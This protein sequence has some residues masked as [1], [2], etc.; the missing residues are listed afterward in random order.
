MR[1][2]YLIVLPVLLAQLAAPAGA[3]PIDPGRAEPSA[4]AHT[5]QLTLITGDRVT[6]TVLADGKQAASV[7]ASPRE[8]GAPVYFHTVSDADGYYVIPSDAGAGIASG[9]LDRQLFNVSGLVEQGLTDTIPVITKGT[10]TT[11]RRATTL[12][13]IGATATRID[14][15]ATFWRDLHSP[16]T[17]TAGTTKVW[18]DRTVEVALEQTV[19][20]VGAPAA[21]R[22][23]F[24]GTGVTVAV[25]D[26]GVDT[27]HPDL[28]G[29]IAATA[30]F[31]TDPDA[32]D[33]HGH[34]THVASTV[35]G[36]GTASDGRYRGVA[37]GA[38]LVIGKVLPNSGA[39]PLSAVIAGMEW[40][41]RGG[42]D[43][44][45]MSL[46][47]PPTD[48]TDPGSLAVEALTEETGALFVVASGNDYADA[49][50]GT[51][52]AAAK[53][54]AVGAVDKQD[55]LAPYSNRGPR[56][57]DA[58]VKPELTAPGSDVVA[59]RAAGTAMGSP[60]DDRYTQASGTSMATPHVAG[61]AA[62]L[63][64][65]HPDWSWA[66]LKDALVSTANPGDYTVF[67]GGTGRL[68][69]A[70]AVTQVVRGP[71]AVSI[72][73]IPAPWQE[74]RTQ[75]L[76]YHNDG[77]EPVTLDLALI[78]HGWDGRALPD[79]ALS[80][81]ADRLTVPANGAATVTL[82]VD[83]AAG[84][85]GAYVAL[86]SATAGETRL[87]TAV[88]YYKATAAHRLTVRTLDSAGRPGTPGM[89]I[90]AVKLDGALPNDPFLQQVTWGWGDDTGSVVLNVAGG[91][92][93]VYGAVTEYDV[94]GR[95]TTVMAEPEL[96][97]TGEH[98][99]TL[100]ARRGVPINPR[101]PERTDVLSLAYGTLRGFEGGQFGHG[102]LFDF[103]SWGYYV[104][105]T[106][107]VETGWL[108]AYERWR[109]GTRT[110]E[111]EVG[112]DRIGREELDVL[113]RPFY[114]APKLAGRH[115]LPLVFAG[116]GTPAEL[117]AA[118]VGG[119][120][121]LVR[122]PIPDGE[123]FR[124]GYAFNAA[125]QVTADAAAAGAAA[126]L[127]YVAVPG[128]WGIDFLPGELIPQLSVSYADGEQLRQH[129][130]ERVTR[131]PATLTIEGRLNPERIYQ[132][133]YRTEGFVPDRYDR[134]VDLRGLARID[135]EYRTDRPGLADLT[136][137][138]GFSPREQ[139]QS[140][141][142]SAFWVPAS[143]TEYVGPTAD[144]DLHWLRTTTQ[145]TGGRDL[146]Y[147]QTSLQA[148][149]RFEPGE[150]PTRE[151]WFAPPITHGAVEVPDGYA[152][153]LR[154]AF[155]RHGDFFLPG[156][157]YLDGDP[158]HYAQS[159]H[160]T[161][162]YRLFRDGQEVP[163][164]GST[165]NPRFRLPAGESTYRLDAVDTQPLGPDVRALA[166]RVQ[167]SWTFQSSP[168]PNGA[169]PA[170]YSC[171]VAN[172]AAGCAFQPLLRPRYDLD[173]DGLNRAIAGQTFT[174]H[175]DASPHQAA[176]YDGR[177]NGLTVWASTDGGA[178][179]QPA[180]TYR[181][182]HDRFAVQVEHPRLDRTD[183]FVWLR[184][185]A[186]DSHGNTVEQLIER[187]Y[188]L[189]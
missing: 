88:S 98:T 159:F 105:P 125:Q 111:V 86:V 10:A 112:S 77:S 34:G 153:E 25:L 180:R 15:P 71:G 55:V 91:R 174:F 148:R 14:A 1:A 95:R 182:G 43:V 90:Y 37:P 42:A 145:T 31:T 139:F 45:S 20:Q 67:Q 72:G 17:R 162:T 21:W 176:P 161:S 117:A 115:E 78:G 56:R 58:A 120:A 76:T 23:G 2:R 166:T 5:H 118:G 24:D 171:P 122:I 134:S 68:D 107:R 188:A 12:T 136:S 19:P 110:A 170:G 108:E 99:V 127:P 116:A 85:P 103:D 11:A 152:A 7:Q 27:T 8:G 131:R 36:H 3:A 81:G 62:L 173:L 140:G 96:T 141:L 48:G 33:G 29:R 143:W 104:T 184:T 22:A 16:T 128:A 156:Y 129:L 94:V 75:D 172:L 164:E 79:G 84:D 59:A 26:T 124:M 97:I 186:W 49:H 157:Y 87:R 146:G 50:V 32:I 163:R 60:V 53:A 89:P 175:V 52:A 74:D 41:A 80:L 132:L 119:K 177:V 44:V 123:P 142:A 40:A 155:C 130:S 185:E 6:Y 63:A 169:K 4:I 39:G 66:Q 35:A 28:A 18:L 178:T 9:M 183:G 106:R 38:Q 82:T 121:V 47:G 149:D 158:R 160:A 154:C 61:A 187:A 151:T 73:A 126:V 69:V 57:G 138:A 137:W 51:P 113:Y 189:R 167:T 102:Y 150:L 93:D 144:L 165:T 147:P 83:A 101:M 114:A 100:D 30:N 54:L 135:A 92:Y 133:R 168:P 13:S 65:A 179:W 70:R 181:A 64:Q 109:F 46:T